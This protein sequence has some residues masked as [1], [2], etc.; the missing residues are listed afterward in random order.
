MK[1]YDTV[2]Q[3]RLLVTL[4]GYGDGPWLCGILETFCDCQ[5]VVPRQNGFHV[6]DFPATRGTIQ[7]GLVC[8]TIFNVVVDNVIIICMAMKI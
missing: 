6:L 5:K 2:D 7:G 8:P 4:E 3:D 1:A